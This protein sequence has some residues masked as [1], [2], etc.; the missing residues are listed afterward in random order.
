MAHVAQ[1]Q[2]IHENKLIESVKED[3]NSGVKGNFVFSKNVAKLFKYV[4][5]AKNLKSI[6]LSGPGIADDASKEIGEALSESK[7][8]TYL[9]IRKSKLELKGLGRT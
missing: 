5:K 1:D 9:S 7:S 3:K 6:E 8:L 4:C 2:G